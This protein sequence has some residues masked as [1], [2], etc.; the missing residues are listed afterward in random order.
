[1]RAARGPGLLDNMRLCISV[2]ALL[3]ANPAVAEDVTELCCLPDSRGCTD[4]RARKGLCSAF[5]AE[6]ECHKQRL[7]TRPCVWLRG[8]C[9]KGWTN[10]VNQS[11]ECPGSSLTARRSAFLATATAA[12][13]AVHVPAAS[14]A[15]PPPPPPPPPPLPSVEGCKP[16]CPTHASGWNVKCDWKPCQQCGSCLALPKAGHPEQ[17]PPPHEGPRTRIPTAPRPRPQEVP[18]R[19]AAEPAAAEP[20]AAEPATAEPAAAV[21]KPVVGDALGPG[22]IPSAEAPMT[23]KPAAPRLRPQDSASHAAT[24]LGTIPMPSSPMTP[25]QRLSWLREYVNVSTLTSRAASF[26]DDAPMGEGDDGAD[27]D[28]PQTPKQRLHWLRRH[29]SAANLTRWI[30]G[31]NVSSTPAGLFRRTT[32]SVGGALG[33]ALAAG[34]G[35]LAKSVPQP[36]ANTWHAVRGRVESWWA[37]WRVWWAKALKSWGWVLSALFWLLL[38]LWLCYCLRACM[39]RYRRR[40]LQITYTAI[41]SDPFVNDDDDDSPSNENRQKRRAA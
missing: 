1:M 40:S 19:A 23:R 9:V 8:K 27:S 25:A 29:I 18:P 2:L 39:R 6:V 3:V 28:K 10:G 4:L 37:T 21:T 16:W 33:G 17:K 7:G 20:A 30:S 38:L 15:T 32:A 35:R 26:L 31:V 41:E 13:Q 11:P 34:G 14:L 12:S 22:A 5:M 24:E 36:W